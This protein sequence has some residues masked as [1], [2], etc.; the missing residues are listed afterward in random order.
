MCPSRHTHYF[1]HH[2]KDY[3][4]KQWLKR[5]TLN[6]IQNR[7]VQQQIRKY[8]LPSSQMYLSDILIDKNMKNMFVEACYMVIKAQDG[9]IL[10]NDFPTFQFC[11]QTELPFLHEYIFP[12]ICNY[13]T[14]DESRIYSF[15]NMLFSKEMRLI[16]LL[17]LSA[18]VVDCFLNRHIS[19]NR[20]Y[21]DEEMHII[22][23]R[24][25]SFSTQTSYSFC[26]LFHH[27][28]NT[29]NDVYRNNMTAIFN[30]LN[31]IE[32]NIQFK[33]YK[34]TLSPSQLDKIP[35]NI[36][37]V[38]FNIDKTATNVDNNF[39]EIKQCV[40]ASNQLSKRVVF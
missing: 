37:S 26:H 38:R 9:S 18:P 31:K 1:K 23:E 4:R 2:H 15:I 16:V 25:F 27:L 32:L 10:K 22:I 29:I 30:I 19:E 13:I 33:P 21:L 35:P 7:P 11:C 28:A 3:T 8:S 5:I 14:I 34:T 17:L 6:M 39:T 20:V 12:H 24:L 40:L 36:L